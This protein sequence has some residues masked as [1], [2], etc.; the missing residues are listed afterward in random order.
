MR[1]DQLEHVIRASAA[2]AD[3][4]E[5]VVVGSQAILGSYPDAPAELRRAAGANVYPNNHRDRWQLIDGSIGE[6]SPFHNTFGYYGSGGAPEVPALP[7][8][9]EDR[10]VAISSTSSSLGRGATGLCLE[11]HDLV[12]SKLVCGARRDVDFARVAHQAGMIDL[13]T[14]TERLAVTDRADELCV[15][16][17]GLINSLARPE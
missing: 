15:D 7:A 2:I 5:I 16:V 6:L 4:N 17:A 8:G 3:D 1:R 10:L 12:I 13:D 11:P 14:L 9:W